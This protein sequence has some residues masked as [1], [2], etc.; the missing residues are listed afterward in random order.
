MS[1]FDRHSFLPLVF[2]TTGSTGQESAVGTYPLVPLN[3]NR[4]ESGGLDIFIEKQ[5]PDF[6]RQNYPDFILFLEAYYEY[7]NTE[8]SKSYFSL[9]NYSDVDKTIDQF[10]SSFRNTYLKNFPITLAQDVDFS[11]LVK[12]IKDFYRL[13]GTE[14]SFKFLMKVL[15]NSNSEFIYPKE[16]IIRVSDGRYIEET[17]VIC[18]R[19]TGS[20]LFSSVNTRITQKDPYTK[21]ISASAR[22]TRV[23]FFEKDGLELCEVF[24][25]DIRGTFFLDYK[26]TFNIGGGEYKETLYN[27]YS[28]VDITSGGLKYKKGEKVVINS[29][30][31]NNFDGIVSRIDLDGAVKQIE[32]RNYG[33]TFTSSKLPLKIVSESGSG[34]VGTIQAGSVKKYEPYFSG[35]KGLLSST[36]RIQDNDYYQVY[37]YVLKTENDLRKYKEILKRLIHPIGMKVFGQVDL[38]RNIVWDKTHYSQFEQFEKSIIGH[39]TPYTFGTTY[40]LRENGNESSGYWLGDTGDL[41]P[42]GYNPIAATGPTGSVFNQGTQGITFV[43][44]PEGGTTSHDPLEKPL[45]STGTDGYTAA[46][47]FGYEYWV[48]YKHPNSR[49]IDTIPAGISFDGIT[50]SNFFKIRTSQTYRSDTGYTGSVPL[51]PTP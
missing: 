47:D 35:N 31:Y 12:N 11:Q 44:V 41:Y 19:N 4:T 45:G 9:L 48:I 49:N 5:V 30:T 7:L 43:T 36:G 25:N 32:I 28:T 42:L 6:V 37:S 23:E 38:L 22:V 21:K 14:A 18:S 29:D 1:Q 26:I 10:I 8:N 15:F 39:Y 16:N 40:D 50:L 27:T 24:I 46:Q 51:G 17:S 2:R 20:N 34:F 13:K 33:K 3:S